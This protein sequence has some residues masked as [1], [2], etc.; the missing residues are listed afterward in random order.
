MNNPI[1]R[2]FMPGGMLPVDNLYGTAFTGEEDAHTFRI[3]YYEGSEAVA[4]TGEI[5]GEF[6]NPAGVTVPLSGSLDEDGRAI[7]TLDEHCYA[8][9]GRFILTIWAGRKV[10]YCGV[11]QVMNSQTDTIDYPTSGIPDVA[12]LIEQLQTILNNW[13]ADYS[14]LQSDV[15][16]LK[17][18][19]SGDNALNI[20][21]NIHTGACKDD[22]TW[23]VTTNK[24]AL[25]HVVSGQ[26]VTITANSSYYTE[27]AMLKTA[28]IVSGDAVDYSAT[29]GFTNKIKVNTGTTWTG[30]VPSDATYL[31][32]F[33]ATAPNLVRK[34]AKILI[35]GYDYIK[36]LVSNIT[37]KANVT[38]V[39]K[40]I[41]DANYPVHIR[42]MQ[43]NCGMWSM[44]N[45]ESMTSDNFQTKMDNYKR[46][47][48]KYKPD[49]I[50]IQEWVNDLTIS[51]ITGTQ[52]VSAILF[53]DIWPYEAEYIYT[54]SPKGRVIKSKWELT[55]ITQ[56]S[57]AGTQFGYSSNCLYSLAKFSYNGRIVAVLTTAIIPSTQSSENIT[58][59]AA[60]LPKL[61]ALIADEDYAF[62]MCDL[63]NVGN[64]DD[65]SIEAEGASLLTIAQ[66]NGF[67]ATMGSYYPWTAT[68]KAYSDP[69]KVG[70]IDNIFYKANGKTLF[71]DWTVPMDEYADL[72]SD[73]I[74]CIGEFILL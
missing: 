39:D 37:D 15:S 66:N 53:D 63:N 33:L 62:L 69:T 51:G 35:D 72:M 56:G 20:S 58:I 1:D 25:Y 36:Q 29:T 60:L 16:D 42:L 55:D 2:R 67:T 34:P 9:A 43:Y 49:V 28:N 5:A 46:F 8:V 13:P 10:I 70:A 71:V 23:Q 30:N 14:Q 19:I 61:L 3:T 31:Y 47:F 54:G 24:C 22:G 11:G 48:C 52:D 6:I 50:G 4:F 7:V 21:G 41:E 45:H 26:T 44:G 18:A 40:S 68:Y 27:I 64:G 65:V 59:R 12:A 38:Y 74:P 57:I 32:I 17:T 73:H